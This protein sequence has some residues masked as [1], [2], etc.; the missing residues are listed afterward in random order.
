MEPRVHV[1]VFATH[2]EGKYRELSH[3]AEKYGIE[4]NVLGWNTMWVSFFRKLVEVHE[5]TQSVDPEDLVVVIDAFDTRIRGGYPEII[6][7]WT[8]LGKPDVVF[9]HDPSLFA[10]ASRRIFGGPLNA[11]LYMGRAGP[12]A[13][14]Q[15]LAL[16]HEAKCKKDDQCAFN[17]VAKTHAS[18]IT[19]SGKRLFY[20]LSYS[21]RSRDIDSLGSTAVFYGYPGTL[22]CTRLWRGVWEYTPF[23][24]PEIAALVC[25]IVIGFYLRSRGG[26]ATTLRGRR[27]K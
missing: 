20:N 18:I 19:D 22:T 6:E 24:I 23:F 1:V 15:E 21:E 7:Q 12:L 16:H 3:D 14:V 10:Y 27:R 13:K 25:V 26:S 5:F 17:L 11:G 9:S 2:S 8:N 4:L